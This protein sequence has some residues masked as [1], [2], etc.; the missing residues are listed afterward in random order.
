M[1]KQKDS[2]PPKE[3][4][5]RFKGQDIQFVHP[6]KLPSFWIKNV[7]LTGKTS[8]GFNI[9]CLV[10]DICFQPQVI[11]KPTVI[12]LTG[13]RQD[14]AAISLNATLNHIAKKYRDQFQ[15]RLTGVPIVDYPLSDNDYLPRK[16]K[17]GLADSRVEI[18]AA[19]DTLDTR[20]ILEIR[21][22]H[23]EFAETASPE[24]T[25][26]K[27]NQLVR[28]AFSEIHTVSLTS[29][30]LV[31]KEKTSITIKSNL[32]KVFAQAMKAALGKEVD[33]IKAEVRNKVDAQIEPYKQ[34]LE[35][36][37][38]AVTSRL[39][40]EKD[41]LDAQIKQQEEAI[42]AKKK[43]LDKE[44]KKKAGDKGKKLLDNLLK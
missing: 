40:D 35:K 34:A 30:L 44:I 27:L 2:K 1:D 26:I 43:E 29:R 13:T 38:T 39:E 36:E 7:N 12:K 9:E 18:N 19:R 16:L 25:M 10:T 15:V 32:D 33:R 14:K 41:K 6:Q 42:D 20:L 5:P 22:S 17:K 21:D 24:K 8:T 31:E 23:F 3:K 4:K 37:I 11:N 28:D